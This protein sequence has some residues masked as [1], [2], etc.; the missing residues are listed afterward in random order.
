[1]TVVALYL[2]FWLLAIVAVAVGIVILAP[3]FIMCC[4][5]TIFYAKR[6]H[7]LGVKQTPATHG[8]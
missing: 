5:G 2:L 3:L 1:M 7:R 8:P 4:A 6:G